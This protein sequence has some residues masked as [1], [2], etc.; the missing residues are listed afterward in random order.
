MR[1]HS[2]R[3]CRR[4][5]CKDFH[6]RTAHTVRRPRALCVLIYKRA[7]M[8]GGVFRRRRCRRH[9]ICLCY[10]WRYA[11][12]SVYVCTGA[13][14]LA[15]QF[16]KRTD[17]NQRSSQQ[18]HTQ[19]QNSH[20]LMRCGYRRRQMERTTDRAV[21]RRAIAHYA[22]CARAYLQRNNA[23]QRGDPPAAAACLVECKSCTTTPAC[24]HTRHAR[25]PATR[26]TRCTPNKFF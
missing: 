5:V 2:E 9:A 13:A 7:M 25:P 3:H 1:V 8:L 11:V 19:K 16:A 22:H 26:V 14:A 23:S 18:T 20:V 12:C 15:W 10:V 21:R 6:K 17:N 4:R 24:D